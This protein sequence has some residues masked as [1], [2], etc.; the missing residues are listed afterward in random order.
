MDYEAASCKRFAARLAISR[1]ARDSMR[2]LKKGKMRGERAF[3]GAKFTNYGLQLGAG[4][5]I[6]AS[7]RCVA[8]LTS[9]SVNPC[10]A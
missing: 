7:F 6:G 3:L 2:V 10:A 8:G 4:K 9:A 5:P 1:G